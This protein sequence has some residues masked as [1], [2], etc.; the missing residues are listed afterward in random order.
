MRKK[1]KYKRCDIPTYSQAWNG[2]AS[3]HV[4]QTSPEPRQKS[5]LNKFAFLPPTTFSGNA[6]F[7]RVFR[8]IRPEFTYPSS[9]LAGK[10]LPGPFPDAFR[11]GN[12]PPYPPPNLRPFTHSLAHNLSHLAKASQARIAKA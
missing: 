7:R 1:L 9:P 8:L 12:S 3:E 10:P 4:T 6:L 2:D 5:F 11:N